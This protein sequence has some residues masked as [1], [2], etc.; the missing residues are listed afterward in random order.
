MCR[1]EDKGKGPTRIEEAKKAIEDDTLL[2]E[3]PFDQELGGQKYRFHHA[4][5]KFMDAK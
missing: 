2:G 3:G 5:G 4:V 1:T